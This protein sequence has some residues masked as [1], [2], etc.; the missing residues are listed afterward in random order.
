[1]MV[2]EIYEK[3]CNIETPF[4]NYLV[5]K[6]DESNCYFGKDAEG[7]IV[8]MMESSAPSVPSVYQETKSLRFIF[9]QRCKLQFDSSIVSKT[10]HVFFCLETESEK[11]EAFIRLTKAF[12]C[13]NSEL[14]QYYLARLFSSISALF[15]KQRQVS[16]N[17]VQGLFVELY[18]ILFLRENGCDIAKCWQSRKR[19]KFDFS[20]DYRRRIE[21]KSTLKSERVHHFR[22]DQLLCELYDIK[23]VSIMIRKNDRGIS[24]WDVIE[25]IRELYSDDFALMLH[26]ENTILQIDNDY[27]Y[28]LKYDEIYLKNNFRF[29]DAKDIPHFN[30]KTPDGIFNVEYDCHMDASSYLSKAEIINWIREKENV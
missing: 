27:L 18:S 7:N 30:E 26:I 21:I 1:M 25:R 5:F 28:D 20:L 2:K 17:E 23:I 6:V 4:N 16:E 24:L 14:D 19:M 9:N 10:M 22:H 8:F 12:T 29:Y 11:V 15:D 3:I 13:S